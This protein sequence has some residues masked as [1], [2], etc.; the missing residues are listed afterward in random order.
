MKSAIFALS[1]SLVSMS[2]FAGKP[3]ASASISPALAAKIKAAVKVEL[4]K[5]LRLSLTSEFGNG[6][7]VEGQYITAQVEVRKGNRTYDEKTDSVGAGEHWEA[8]E[9]VS[10]SILESEAKK[11]NFSEMWGPSNVCLE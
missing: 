1:L 11:G 9:G 4:S 5:D 2:A 3:A 7:G 6:C 10:Y 8:L